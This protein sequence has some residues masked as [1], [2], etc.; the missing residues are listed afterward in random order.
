MKNIKRILSLV[1]L[2]TLTLSVLTLSACS[3]GEVN[4]KVTVKDAAGNPYTTGVI[5]QF[6]KNGEQVAMQTVDENGVAAKKLEGGKYGIALK[7]ADDE[8]ECYYD[9]GLQVTAKDNEIDVTV[10]YKITS[11]PEVIFAG[12]EQFDAYTINDGSYYTELSG[13]H[14]NYFLFVPT[15]A[16]NYEFSVANN[17][18]TQIGYYGSTHFVQETSAAEVVDN[19]FTVSVTADMIGTGQGGTSVLVIGVDLLKGDEGSCILAVNRTGDPEK[20]LADEPWTVYEKTVELS[21]YSLQNGAKIKEFDLTAPTSK[22]NLVL[23]ETDGFYHLDSKD[24]PLVLVRLA[25]D[26]QY[27]A[28]FKTMLDRSGVVKYFFDENDDF[29][30]KESYS[31]CLLEYIDNADEKAGVYPL[32]EDL[33]YIIQQRGEYA[34]WWDFESS[35]FRFQDMDGNN[36]EEINTEI[37]WLL[38]CCYIE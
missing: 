5:V 34:Q 2:M 36:M 22:Y 3:T 4:Y 24:G 29:I 27:I 32:T 23:N 28:C 16:G 7:F 10:A 19:K 38:M 33:K 17:E 1:L 18:D 14:R 8:L 6:I 12:G 26:C 21:P 11:E 30:K 9:E 31:E 20:T 25:E 37:A 13:K 35:N 15:K